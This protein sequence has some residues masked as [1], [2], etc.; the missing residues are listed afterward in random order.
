MMAFLA[1]VKE[2]GVIGDQRRRQQ[3]GRVK[4]GVASCMVYSLAHACMMHARV[5]I[6]ERAAFS[7]SI[8]FISSEIASRSI[9]FMMG[10]HKF[11]TELNPDDI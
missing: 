4:K 6:Y 9:S 11:L 1:R 2:P 5:F 7:R 10:K 3:T 8:T